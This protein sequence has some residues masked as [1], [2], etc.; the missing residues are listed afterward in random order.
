MNSCFYHYYVISFSCQFIWKRFLKYRFKLIV[1]R[2][3]CWQTSFLM[4]LSLESSNLNTITYR[5]DPTAD[6]GDVS[7]PAL[8]QPDP[9]VGSTIQ[10]LDRTSAH[11]TCTA[12][13]EF[14]VYVSRTTFAVP[15]C[16]LW[17]FVIAV[18]YHT[19]NKRVHDLP[20]GPLSGA[21]T[22]AHFPD[23][24]YTSAPKTSRK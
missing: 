10:V 20:G 15:I 5:S 13:R 3:K 22:K 12:L 14:I 18:M 16:G 8:F 19:Y 23:F 11:S 2:R 21:R 6:E 7:Y 24:S 17:D 4:K 1:N 9:P